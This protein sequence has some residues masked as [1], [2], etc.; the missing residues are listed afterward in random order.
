[1][2]GFLLGALLGAGAVWFLYLASRREILRL[3]EEKLL[4]Q[5]E[6]LIVVDFMHDLVEGIG[7]G[8]ERD[9]LFQRVVHSSILSTGALSACV[10]ELSPDNRLRG[11]AVEGLFPPQRE[12][13]RSSS[14]KLSTRAKF[15]EQ[16]L[17]SESFNIGESIIGYAAK[18]GTPLLIAD[19]TQDPRVIQHPDTSLKV[20]SLIVVPITFRKSLIGVL[21]VANPTDGM[22]FNETDFSLVQSL[23]EQAG[24]AIHNA[25]LMKVQIE[26]NRLDYDITMASSI[27]AMILPNTFPD[28]PLLDIAAA[29]RPAQKIG[30]DLYDVFEISPGKIGISVADVSGKGIAASLLMAICQANL[31]RFATERESP[32]NALRDL[33]REIVE[34]MRQDMFVTFIYA[35]IDTSAGTLTVAR[36]GHEL[37]LL[38]HHNSTNREL[39]VSSIGSEGMAVGMVPSEIF[40]AIIEDRTV[41]FTQGD[42]VTLYTD[43]ITEA[44]NPD[45]VEFSE[46]RLKD[47]L[48]TLR[49]RPASEINGGI[50]A[51]VE[52]FTGDSLFADDLTLITVRHL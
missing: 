37:P 29:Y 47:I 30:G 26:K 4:L 20:R 7:E 10:Y 25:D 33:N 18:T 50:I 2:F 43:G 51:N 12:L 19:A 15:I 46:T 27:Q 21:A 40:D 31:R 6:K 14:D 34:K 28:N 17:K 45:G 49:E 13:P 23:A 5:Q 3:E 52:R 9:E 39:H 24:M 32:A 35:V 38:L 1:M 42:I 48:L 16:V 41:P 11:V 22:A 44:A 36:A 8:V